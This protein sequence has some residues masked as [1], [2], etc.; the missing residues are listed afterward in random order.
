MKKKTENY[1]ILAC[2]FVIMICAILVS[3]IYGTNKK[4]NKFVFN[5]H[6]DEEALVIS[7]NDEK[8][9]LTLKDVSYYVLIMEA[10]G[11]ANAKLYD[12]SKKN[13]FWNIY[14]NNTFVKTIAK[15]NAMNLCIR[16]NVYYLEAVANNVSLEPVELEAVEEETDFIYFSLTGKQLD[17]TTLDRSDIY[18]IR[19]KIALAT[20][21]VTKLMNEND[22][23]ADT[24]NIDGE[25]YTDLLDSYDIE[26]DDLWDNVELG[27]I[28]I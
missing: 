6:L 10:T 20:K 19:Y 14:I 5:E 4:N 3:I 28:T 24:L 1:I 23:S 17:A 2:V 18:N 25:Y 22:L 21:Y 13:A 11:D 26:I 15:E 8:H 7:K 9:P 16:D 27:S 12:P